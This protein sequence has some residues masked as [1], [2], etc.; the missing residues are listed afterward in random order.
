MKFKFFSYIIAESPTFYLCMGFDCSR[1]FWLV[2]NDGILFKDFYG[3]AF[4][5]YF[6][7]INLDPRREEKVKLYTVKMKEFLGIEDTDVEKDTSRI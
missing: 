7:I 1:L 2:L 6:L 4:L 5:D 3:V